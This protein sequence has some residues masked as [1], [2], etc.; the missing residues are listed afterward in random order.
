MNGWA[1]YPEPDIGF[2]P[3]HNLLLNIHLSWMAVTLFNFLQNSYLDRFFILKD[4]IQIRL[5]TDQ[6]R[7]TAEKQK[8]WNRIHFGIFFFGFIPYG[9]ETEAKKAGTNH[10]GCVFSVI[11]NWHRMPK[12]SVVDRHFFKENPDRKILSANLLVTNNLC[13]VWQLC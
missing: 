1:E 10:F 9:I 6:I 4:R 7:N 8:I 5:D 11:G 3:N 2:Q 12:I 13:L